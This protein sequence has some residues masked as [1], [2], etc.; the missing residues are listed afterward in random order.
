MTWDVYTYFI[1][2][3]YLQQGEKI[4][5][6]YL[7]Q[8]EVKKDKAKISGTEIIFDDS[9]KYEAADFEKNFTRPRTRNK[10][11]FKGSL[12]KFFLLKVRDIQLPVVRMNHFCY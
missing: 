11:F 8:L 7:I 4:N 3:A 5:S 10:D 1:R 6:S 9:N 2:V 12:T